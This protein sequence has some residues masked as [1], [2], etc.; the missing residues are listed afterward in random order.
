MI[1]ASAAFR[2]SST[3]LRATITEAARGG[4]QGVEIAHRFTRRG[5]GRRRI[6]RALRGI[7]LWNEVRRRLDQGPA[8]EPA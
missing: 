7:G 8:L 6:R 1:F 5:S 3:A 2:K 4:A